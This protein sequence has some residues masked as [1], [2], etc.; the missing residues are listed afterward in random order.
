VLVTGGVS[1]LPV[2]QLVE[3]AVATALKVAAWI[4]LLG[5]VADLCLARSQVLEK[6]HPMAGGLKKPD[7]A[8][9]QALASVPGVQHATLPRQRGARDAS[10]SRVVTA[11]VLGAWW[12]AGLRFPVLFFG[13]GATGLEWGPAM[14]RLY[15]VLVIA[16]VT[17]LAELLITYFRP[18]NTMAFRVTRY[19]WLIAGVALVYLVV[20]SDAQWMVWRAESAARAAVTVLHIAG[21]NVSLAQ[22]VNLVWSTVF[23]GVAVASAWSFLKSVLSRF[24]GTPMTA[25]A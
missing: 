11:M 1:Q 9:R 4:T 3:N 5:A 7:L 15:P 19:V 6:W 22:F 25:P 24:R 14:D 2:G 18:E 10:I 12:L 13:P 23:V 21:R 8:V 16:Q 20:T 17:M